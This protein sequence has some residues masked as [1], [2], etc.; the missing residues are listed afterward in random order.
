M[1]QV[2][3]TKPIFS[4][5]L[6]LH[7]TFLT[8]L[9]IPVIQQEKCTKSE[10]RHKSS[11]GWCIC[12]MLCWQSLNSCDTV[13]RR[14]LQS[15]SE[16]FLCDVVI[17]CHPARSCST[18]SCNCYML[19]QL[20]LGGKVGPMQRQREKEVGWNNKFWGQTKMQ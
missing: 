2:W 12:L 9:P 4:K 14:L 18:S 5:T 3:D 11:H 8:S 10:T 19:S 6:V 13:I 1:C 16:A 17:G 7:L 20:E 15:F